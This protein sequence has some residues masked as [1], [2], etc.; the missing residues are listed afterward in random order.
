MRSSA[1]RFLLLLSLSMLMV[2]VSAIMAADRHQVGASG[3]ASAT[4]GNARL[5][6]TIGQTITGRTGDLGSGFLATADGRYYLP[7]D[8]DGNHMLNI[9]DAVYLINFIF[10]GGPAPTPYVG[11]DADCNGVVN[12]A[13]ALVIIGYIFGG[14]QM[15]TYCH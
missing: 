10:G 8:A 2:T 12:I 13:D 6:S 9:A 15:P 5:A 3:S 11:G 1:S 14:G 4:S 7:G